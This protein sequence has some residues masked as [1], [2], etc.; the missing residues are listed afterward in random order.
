MNS[1]KVKKNM[2]ICSKKRG[3]PCLVNFLLRLLDFPSL[4]ISCCSLL[5]RYLLRHHLFSYSHE[6]QL[7]SLSL[8]SLPPPVS[9]HLIHFP[10]LFLSNIDCFTS[11]MRDE[12]KEKRGKYA[13]TSKTHANF[14]K[15]WREMAVKNRYKF[16]VFCVPWGISSSTFRVF[17]KNIFSCLW[18]RLLAFHF[19]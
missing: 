16:C 13:W 14:G 10:Y 7:I 18:Y 1:S 9:A 5:T 17:R 2:S 3:I 15:T 6:T 12:W 8:S 11:S 4:L 19:V